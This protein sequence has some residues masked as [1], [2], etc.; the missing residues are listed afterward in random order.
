MA[1]ARLSAIRGM[2]TNLIQRLVRPSST[3]HATLI[4]S[5]PRLRLRGGG[6]FFLRRRSFQMKSRRRLRKLTGNVSTRHCAQSRPGDMT[7]TRP[8]ANPCMEQADENL[9]TSHSLRSAVDYRVAG[10]RLLSRNDRRSTGSAR[11][12]CGKR[13][14]RVPDRTHVRHSDLRGQ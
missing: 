2:F 3:E 4:A 1:L 14:L 13:T 5:L 7:S 10:A 12:R 11:R 9:P 8:I 6:A